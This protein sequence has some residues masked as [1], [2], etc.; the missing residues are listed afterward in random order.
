[1]SDSFSP[2]T[3]VKIGTIQ[4][5]LARAARTEF[6][7]ERESCEAKAREIMLSIGVDTAAVERVGDVAEGKRREE[8]VEGGVFLWQRNLWRGLAEMN[9]CFYS[10]ESARTKVDPPHRKKRTG[11]IVHFIQRKRHRLIGRAVNV[12]TTRVF[13]DYLEAA[14]EKALRVDLPAGE[15]PNRGWAGDF[16]DGAIDVLLTKIADRYRKK[17]D[18][19]RAARTKKRTD[20]DGAAIFSN[21]R[22]LTLT[23]V[24][25]SEKAGN[26][27]FI[28]GEG[29]W[30]RKLAEDAEDAK[31]QADAIAEY[32]RIAASNPE[33]AK[34]T[35]AERG[36][37]WGKRRGGSATAEERRDRSRDPHAF[38]AGREAGKSIGIDP[39]VDGAAPKARR[40]GK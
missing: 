3:L 33:E 16:R 21:S 15:S 20:A 18:A 27:D 30:A 8:I 12:A 4:K 1:M 29:A 5:L 35:F 25:E 28:H 36:Y 34:K 32:R 6:A 38:R 7:P 14:V 13:A 23:D 10:T 39:G 31:H 19:E 17:L 37:A 24:V 40:L 9:F 2:E 11:A 26:Y 22:A